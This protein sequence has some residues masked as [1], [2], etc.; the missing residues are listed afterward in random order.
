MTIRA[1]GGKLFNADGQTDMPKLTVALRNFAIA[2]KEEPKKT[3]NSINVKK[4]SVHFR[5]TPCFNF[6]HV[7]Y[8]HY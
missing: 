8:V 6:K 2:P 4:N 3:P 5:I 7:S 1:V